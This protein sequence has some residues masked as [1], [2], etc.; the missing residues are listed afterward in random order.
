M[1]QFG[2]RHLQNVDGLNFYKLLGSGKG[3]GF[4][5]YPDW[6]TYALLTIWDTIEAAETFIK[7]NT[8]IAAYQEKGASVS[9]HLMQPFR[10]H[11]LWSGVNP[12]AGDEVTPKDN[13]RICILTRATIKW[14]KLRTFWKYVPTSKLGLAN[15]PDLIYTKGV[16]EVP[17][18]QMATF[19]I[20][21]NLEA[22][23]QFAYKS[24]EHATAVKMT[25]ELKWYKEE[26]FARFVLLKSIE[27]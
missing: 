8:L 12:F 7:N 5:P 22:V 18:V 24:K 3:D 23:K 27:H 4:N 17:F 11:G 10:S 20:W 16:G 6:G 2:H 21:K 9:H 14:S 15:N 13:D 25:R 26:L 19:S 1:M